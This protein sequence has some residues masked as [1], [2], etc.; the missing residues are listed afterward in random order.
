MYKQLLP[1]CNA[2]QDVLMLLC[3]IPLKFVWMTGWHVV[4]HA[5]DTIREKTCCN[6][7]LAVFGSIVWLQA[8]ILDWSPLCVSSANGGQDFCKA[9]CTEDCEKSAIIGQEVPRHCSYHTDTLILHGFFL[10]GPCCLPF[11]ECWCCMAS[12]GTHLI[13]RPDTTCQGVHSLACFGNGLWIFGKFRQVVSSEW[14]RCCGVQC[15]SLAT[16]GP[17]CWDGFMNL[18]ESVV[19]TCSEEHL[20]WAGLCS[21][22]HSGLSTLQSVLL[23]LYSACC[24]IVMFIRTACRHAAF[25]Y[26][27]TRMH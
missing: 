14:G 20:P 22:I 10:A 23:I 13:Q 18:I 27:R 12:R 5:M 16:L 1:L 7:A 3:K 6:S 9:A 25:S 26:Y 15:L 4:A 11:S 24:L 2:H 21:L 17:I 8:L 19:P